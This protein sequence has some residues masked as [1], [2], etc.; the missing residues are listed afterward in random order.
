MSSSHSMVID[1]YGSAQN[2]LSQHVMN[3]MGA[4]SDI[5]FDI[6]ASG[7]QVGQ[8]LGLAA[9]PSPVA[10]AVN[11]P[12]SDRTDNAAYAT[13]FHSSEDRHRGGALSEPADGGAAASGISRNSRRR[14]INMTELLFYKGL[15][16]Q[17]SLPRHSRQRWYRSA[18]EI[19]RRNARQRRPRDQVVPTQG[20]SASAGHN[21]NTTGD[22][23]TEDDEE[24][25]DDDDLILDRF[26]QSSAPQD[27]DV[28]QVRVEPSTSQPP[29]DNVP[30][31]DR[32]DEL[33]E[34][35]DELEEETEPGKFVLKTNA[36]VRMHDRAAKVEVQR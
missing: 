15:T 1:G 25:P 12:A 14:L 30:L 35:S 23:A 32:V 7:P 17:V 8:A 29:R 3:I 21:L 22:I 26:T 27:P 6:G 5:D 24:V 19:R 20:I 31:P 34:R 9:D 16:R 13:P 18:T 36:C 2:P 33:E 4:D 10:P 11:E 28:T